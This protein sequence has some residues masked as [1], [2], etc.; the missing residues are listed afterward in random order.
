V[1]RKIRS[2]QIT[3]DD[4]PR[5]IRGAFHTT[6][7]ASQWTGTPGSAEWPSQCGPRHCGQLASAGRIGS[8]AARIRAKVRRARLRNESI[9]LLGVRKQGMVIAQ[10]K[11]E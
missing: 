6:E 3:G 8:A 4:W 1:V 2:P 9:G 7:C 5:P 10:G 11:A